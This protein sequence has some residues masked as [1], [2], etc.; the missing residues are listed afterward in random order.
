MQ[1]KTDNINTSLLGSDSFKGDDT[2]GY[3]DTTQVSLSVALREN[4][5]EMNACSLPKAAMDDTRHCTPSELYRSYTESP[6]LSPTGEPHSSSIGD[7]TT[8]GKLVF[9]WMTESMK[10]FKQKS[11]SFCDASSGAESRP[12]G[13]GGSK[14]TR[15][16]YTS[17]QLLELEKEFHFNHYLGKPRRLEMANL[18]KLSERQIK[19]WFQNRRMRHKKDTKLKGIGPPPTPNACLPSSL[20]MDIS[21]SLKS[22]T[23]NYTNPPSVSNAR[24]DACCMRQVFRNS[25]GHWPYAQKHRP[26][27]DQYSRRLNEGTGFTFSSQGCFSNVEGNCEDFIAFSQPQMRRLSHLRSHNMAGQQRAGLNHRTWPLTYPSEQ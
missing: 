12:D 17:N 15:T 11:H 9:P 20:Q 1:N 16:S 10:K 3:S 6:L 24:N 23:E 18:L 25:E 4:D 19:I 22:P 7:F 2:F 8:D 26:I 21:A 5:R 27:N 14:R 13:S